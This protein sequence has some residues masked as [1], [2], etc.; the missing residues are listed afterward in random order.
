MAS[1]DGEGFEDAQGAVTGGEV[2][3]GRA[4][5]DYNRYRVPYPEE[6]FNRLKTFDIDFAQSRLLDLGTGTG[7]LARGFARRGADVVGIDIDPALLAAARQVAEPGSQPSYVRAAAEDLPLGDSAVGVVTA[8]QC[9]HWFDR[10]RVAAAVYRAIEP[11]GVLIITHLDWLPLPGTV[12][13]ATEDLIL[14]WN[15]EWRGAGR[16]GFYPAWAQDVIAAGFTAVETFSF[17]I[18]VSFTHEAW[19]GRI[20]ASAGVGG[21]LTDE[22]VARFD[23]ALAARL[24][25]RFPA[26]PLEVPHRSFTLVC[27]APD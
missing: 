13:A 20:R 6:L 11:G 14:E 26:E 24:D 5:A 9:W 8:G 18:D 16:F 3:F 23:D 15:P 21:S 17:D 27:R 25:D 1:G 12:V 7:F 22:A 10:E 4:A 2:E 19:R